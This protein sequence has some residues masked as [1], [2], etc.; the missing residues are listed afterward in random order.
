MA[1]KRA[2]EARVCMGDLGGILRQKILKSRGP[3]M[4]F[5]AFS[6][7][8]F[9]KKRTK[10]CNCRLK[11]KGG[12]GLKVPQPPPCSA[13]PV[14]VH[15]DSPESDRLPCQRSDVTCML[16]YMVF[17]PSRPALVDQLFDLLK[18]QQKKSIDS[19][20]NTRGSLNER[21]AWS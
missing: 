16:G 4:V 20:R 9:F 17:S 2:R 18:S 21:E 14:N 15:V 6:M 3:A 12:G 5:S 1:C 10:K 19:E 11:L 8:C 13:V 7:R